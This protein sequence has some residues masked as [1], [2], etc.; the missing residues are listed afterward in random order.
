MNFFENKNL[1]WHMEFEF[2]NEWTS[3]K[4]EYDTVKKVKGDVYCKEWRKEQ[5][6]IE[7][8]R[9]AGTR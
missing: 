1:K 7:M 4:E 6:Q 2:I 9:R 3:L 5:Q 8:E